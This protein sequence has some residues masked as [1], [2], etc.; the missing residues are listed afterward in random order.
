MR[1]RYGLFVSFMALL[2]TGCA[3]PGLAEF[4]SQATEWIAFDEQTPPFCGRCDST[5][6]VAL[7]NGRV[8]FERG[9]WE[10]NYRDW[11]AS[12]R[13]VQ[14]SSEQYARF[15]EALAPYKPLRDAVPDAECADYITDQD[16]AIV[17]WLEDGI[18]VTRVF[19]F[20]CL[21]DRG[22]ND[23]VRNS[24]QLLTAH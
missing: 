8:L 15:R 1:V 20:G 23:A 21:D 3:N 12:R 10:G 18:E 4:R 13:A 5:R 14:V 16:G 19:D 2:L 24:V 22:M 11:R 9:H 7:S 17:V 6:L